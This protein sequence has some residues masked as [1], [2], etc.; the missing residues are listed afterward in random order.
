MLTENSTFEAFLDSAKGKKI[1]G[2]GA[3]NHV[4]EIKAV[5][6]EHKL[7][8]D[9]IVDNDF[10]KWGKNYCNIPVRS[11]Y[12]LQGL[13]DEIVVLICTMRPFA[14]EKQLKK[15]GITDVYAYCLWID[16]IFNN[17][18]RGTQVFF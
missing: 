18:G 2:F 10:W 17:I 12:N 6:A 5:L 11:P 13:Q 4:A 9:Y 7:Q 1:V 8:I 3:S 16:F 15:I 14:I